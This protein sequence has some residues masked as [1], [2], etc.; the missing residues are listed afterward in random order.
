MKRCWYCNSDKIIKRN[1]KTENLQT[2][3]DTTKEVEVEFS[4]Y[5]AECDSY[6]RSFSYGHYEEG[7]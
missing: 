4:E 6:L 1:I 3:N 2:Y 5:C 7:K